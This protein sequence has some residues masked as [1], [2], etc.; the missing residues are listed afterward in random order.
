MP[1]LGVVAGILLAATALLSSTDADTGIGITVASIDVDKGLK[2]GTRTDLP[3]VDIFNT[4][5]TPQSYAVV[6]STRTNQ[7]EL[8]PSPSWID[9]SPRKFTLEPGKSQSLDLRLSVPSDARTGEYFA[10]IGAEVDSPDQSIQPGVATKLTFSVVE[11]SWLEGRRNEINRWLEDGMP[12]TALGPA[13]V[14]GLLLFRW[15]S[16]RL[17][18]RLPFEPR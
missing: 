10:L 14:L 12:W 17:R 6:V 13:A 9:V 16:R 7:P 8:R 4:G 1:S 3:A 5:S 18:F 11:T 15:A 2:A